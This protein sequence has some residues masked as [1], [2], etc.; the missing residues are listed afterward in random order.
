MVLHVPVEESVI[1]HTIEVGLYQLKDIVERSN[2]IADAIGEIVSY[3]LHTGHWAGVVMAGGD[4]ATQICLQ[5]GT[6]RF[7]I[8]DEVESG[9]PSGLLCGGLELYAVTKAG[10]FGTNAVLLNS[11]TM[12]KE[13]L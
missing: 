11:V 8:M 1:T 5:L 10:N 3:L 13:L 9:V 4:T 6:E 7:E 12:V 2:S